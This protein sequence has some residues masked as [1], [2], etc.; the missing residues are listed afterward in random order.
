MN[1]RDQHLVRVEVARSKPAAE[2]GLT[3]EGFTLKLGKERSI[4]AGWNFGEQELTRLIR[5]VEAA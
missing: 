5:V 4:Q 1:S 3:A 2:Q